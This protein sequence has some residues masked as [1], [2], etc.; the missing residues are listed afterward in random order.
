MVL[1]S[2]SKV[3]IKRIRNI[4]VNV[5]IFIKLINILKINVG[6]LRNCFLKHIIIDN[7]LLIIPIIK[8]TIET[9]MK[10]DFE[11]GIIIYLIVFIKFLKISCQK[12]SFFYLVFMNI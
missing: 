3:S 5:I 11:L 6:I 8:N 12:K 7:V 9:I 10:T 2:K 1:I 4:V